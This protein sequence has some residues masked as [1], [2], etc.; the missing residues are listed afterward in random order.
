MMSIRKLRNIFL[1][2]DFNNTKKLEI[3]EL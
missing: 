1:K 2:L 3:K